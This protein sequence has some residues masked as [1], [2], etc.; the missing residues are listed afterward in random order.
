MDGNKVELP[1]TDHPLLPNVSNITGGPIGLT[2]LLRIPTTIHA[3]LD[4]DWCDGYYDEQVP[5]IPKFSFLTDASVSIYGASS[6]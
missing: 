2:D 1:T 3:Q 5:R 6:L 4:V